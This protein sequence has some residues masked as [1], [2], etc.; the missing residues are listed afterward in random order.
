MLPNSLLS[1]LR[2]RGWRAV[3]KT[4]WC[5]RQ[6]P[7]HQ[8]SVLDAQRTIRPESLDSSEAPRTSVAARYWPASAGQI[9][10]RWLWA[11]DLPHRAGSGH[12]SS[13]SASAP[14]SI[15]HS[16]W[17]DVVSPLREKGSRQSLEF[18]RQQV[19]S[20]LEAPFHKSFQKA[21]GQTSTFNTFV[22]APLSFGAVSSHSHCAQS[23]WGTTDSNDCNNQRENLLLHINQPRQRSGCGEEACVLHAGGFLRT[24]LRL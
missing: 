1:I 20:L 16:F 10:Q 21:L 2:V 13:W 6:Q 18:V 8:S 12:I 14:G 9:A 11:G 15:P 17:T 24:E 19:C 4:D 5:D 22:F 7:V 3:G 23:K